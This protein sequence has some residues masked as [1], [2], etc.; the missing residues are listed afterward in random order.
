MARAV[1]RDIHKMRAFL[2][3]REAVDEDGGRRFVAWFEP[4]HHILRANAG[5]FVRRFAAMRW[6]ILTPDGMRSA[7]VKSSMPRPPMGLRRVQLTPSIFARS[8]PSSS[9]I[10]R[11]PS[12]RAGLRKHLATGARSA[13]R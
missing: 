8:M 2:R 6:S 4:D 12:M 11:V 1:R 5:F 9:A 10:W 3:F 13:T 7:N